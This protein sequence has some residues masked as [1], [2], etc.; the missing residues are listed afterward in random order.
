MVLPRCV[1]AMPA[2]SA[3]AG[4]EAVPCEHDDA[5]LIRTVA[6]KG[7]LHRTALLNLT[8]IEGAIAD[9]ERMATGG[10]GSVSR[11]HGSTQWVLHLGHLNSMSFGHYT[12]RSKS[13]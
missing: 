12:W 7:R 4:A 2:W 8:A 5:M 13:P 11:P 6:G 3:E 1:F 9:A 10:A